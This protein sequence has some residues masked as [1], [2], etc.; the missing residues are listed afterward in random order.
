[1]R[2]K[3]NKKDK[4]IRTIRSFYL[5]FPRVTN[6]ILHKVN[7]S[8]WFT[9]KYLSWDYDPSFSKLNKQTNKQTI[10]GHLVCLYLKAQRCYFLLKCVALVIC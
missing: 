7:N 10:E 9:L 1:M 8:L 3:A 6:H 5:I 2:K 4:N